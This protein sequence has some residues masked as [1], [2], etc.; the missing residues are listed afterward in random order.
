MDA[1]T[2]SQNFLS[3]I[4]R[5]HHIVRIIANGVSPRGLSNDLM[6]W[7]LLPDS[8]GQLESRDHNLADRLLFGQVEA[9]ASQLFVHSKLEFLQSVYRFS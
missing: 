7:G 8:A 5:L 1:W 3:T 9:S 2:L 6:D 4:I